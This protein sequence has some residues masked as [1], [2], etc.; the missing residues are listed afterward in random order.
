MHIFLERKVILEFLSVHRFNINL[1]NKII[2]NIVKG[3]IQNNRRKQ[4]VGPPF[5]S[6]ISEFVDW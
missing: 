6:K 1:S 4:R 5:W 3:R 2:C